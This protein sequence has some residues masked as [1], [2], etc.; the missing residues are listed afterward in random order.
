MKKIRKHSK[1]IALLL[2]F[3]FI[4]ASCSNQ[5][6]LVNTSTKSSSDNLSTFQRT[7]DLY[8]GEELFRGL[9]FLEG[10]FVNEINSLQESKKNINLDNLNS[11]EKNQVT[12]FH[13]YVIDEIKKTNPNY[14]YEFKKSLENDDLFYVKQI[15]AEA[16][17]LINKIGLSSRGYKQMFEASNELISKGVDFDREDIK[18][19]DLSNR[20]DAEKFF[21]IMEKDYGIEQESLVAATCNLGVW[22][23]VTMVAAVQSVVGVW[24]Y[25]V[26]AK[27]ELWGKAG[28]SVQNEVLVLELHNYLNNK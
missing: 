10:N 26:Y 16:G 9:F 7:S 20:A 19:L 27:V 13:N 25:W 18:N 8:N 17:S 12:I 6:E 3:S 11:E 4:F 1:T 24:V 21:S 15:L 14:F 5:D 22:C 28:Q 23:A 2:T